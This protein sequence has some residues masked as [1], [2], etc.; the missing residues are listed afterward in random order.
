V[1]GGGVLIR[2]SE[3]KQLRLR[4]GVNSTV[5]SPRSRFTSK[6]RTTRVAYQV[7]EAGACM[8][9][10]PKAQVVGRRHTGKGAEKGFS[11]R[12]DRGLW[13]Q[14]KAEK[15]HNIIIQILIAQKNSH[16]NGIAMGQSVLPPITCQELYGRKQT[17]GTK[18][19]GRSG[20]S[21]KNS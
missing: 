1:N 19:S 7:T 10:C 18:R 6:N 21:R 16:S 11:S 15:K 5:S 8:P 13:S 14:L 12:E 20:R 4:G 2:K 17:T 3:D 9:E